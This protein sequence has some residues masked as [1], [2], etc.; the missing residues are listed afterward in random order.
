MLYAILLST[1]LPVA[2]LQD[3][4][5]PTAL[6][7]ERI[8]A[9]VRRERDRADPELY[10]EL[11]RRADAEALLA[12]QECATLVFQPDALESVYA[13]VG[14]FRE[15]DALEA[16]ARAWLLAEVES[17]RWLVH[18]P[19]ARAL[20][21]FGGSAQRELRQVLEGHPDP[22]CR[23]IAV[24]GLLT[25]LRAQGDEEALE[26]LIDNFRPPHSGPREAG[27]RTLRGFR[28]EEH[29]SAMERGIGDADLPASVR[30]M[31]VEALVAQDGED[32]CESLLDALREREVAVRLAALRGLAA[33]GGVEQVR[34]VERRLRSR[35]PALRRAAL[36]TLGALRRGDPEWA[37]EL[38]EYVEDRDVA[39]RLGALEVL[40]NES[41]AGEASRLPLLLRLA[42]DESAL[43]RRHA[44]TALGNVRDVRV[45]PALLDR[46]A[47]DP[48][49]VRDAARASLVKLTGLDLGH[50]ATRWQAWWRAEGGRYVLPTPE[51]AARLVAERAARQEAGATAVTFFGVPLGSDRVAFVVD[52]SGS[53]DSM[54]AAGRPRLEAVVEEL[55]GTLETFP[56]DGRFNLVFFSDKV[57][58]WKKNLVDRDEKSLA[59]AIGFARAQRAVG[60]TAIHDGLVK[61]LE[62]EEVDTIVLLTDGQPT[63]GRI[64]DPEEILADIELRNELRQVVIHCVS[65]SHASTLLSALAEQTGG[66]YHEVN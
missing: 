35:E 56:P 15:V 22:V 23:A 28:A 45:I 65:V 11:A 30:T 16:R 2:S 17:E 48:L 39:L 46:L 27:V 61:A 36:V 5:D 62:D 37:D 21:A 53:M 42:A 19:A 44:A 64:T 55:V 58:R 33:C 26:L 18:H 10:L 52:T 59:R 25:A 20:S 1:S 7:S 57:R 41:R 47:G 32:V 49:R 4:D 31:L 63:E 9:I 8:V 60:G 12:L 54:T 43:V 24:G 14:G 6:A 13:A 34:D 40:A 66:G 50:G 51:E 3:A 29:V 38:A